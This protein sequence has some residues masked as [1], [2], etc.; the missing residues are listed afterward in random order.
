MESLYLIT[1]GFEG[2]IKIGIAKDV[3]SRIAS[4]QTGNPYELELLACFDFRDASFIEKALHQKCDEN[5][6]RGEWYRLT[7]AQVNEIKSI[8]ISLGGIE[9]HIQVYV[10]NDEIEEAE[11]IQEAVEWGQTGA[12]WDYAAMFAD[13]WRMEKTTSKGVNDRY[14]CWRKGWDR[15]GRKYLYGGTIESLPYPEFDEMR[16]YFRNP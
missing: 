7:A 3:E 15:Q 2:F 14:W 5:H 13:G 10:G 12:K 8:C 6:V 11:E 16:K 9:N 1:S 4:L